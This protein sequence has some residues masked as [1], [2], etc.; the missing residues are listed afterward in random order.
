MAC[1]FND[2]IER[3]IVDFNE[4]AFLTE[5][6]EFWKMVLICNKLEMAWL[7]G[8]KQFIDFWFYESVRIKMFSFVPLLFKTI[9]QEWDW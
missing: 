6:I 2:L 8:H 3:T 7:I 5:L 1:Q 4:I 9:C